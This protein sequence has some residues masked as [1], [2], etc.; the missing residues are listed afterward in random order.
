VRFRLRGVTAYLPGIPWS[1]PFMR[2]YAD[3]LGRATAPTVPT[4]IGASKTRP[5]SVNALTI[6]Y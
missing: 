3:A 6:S 2:A 4:D 1:E 5:G